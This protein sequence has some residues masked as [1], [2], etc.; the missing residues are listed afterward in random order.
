MWQSGKI[1]QS[2][3]SS[4]SLVCAGPAP[5]L[6]PIAPGMLRTDVTTQ[7][8]G[9]PVNRSGMYEFDLMETLAADSPITVTSNRTSVMVTNN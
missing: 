3:T 9:M 1:V 8:F 2:V 6:N 4:D 5:L 7:E